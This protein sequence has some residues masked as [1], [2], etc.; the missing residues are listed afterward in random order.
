MAFTGSTLRSR[1]LW[2]YLSLFA[3]VFALIVW[4][5]VTLVAD[6]V[7]ERLLV[8]CRDL[9]SLVS[10][11]GFPLNMPTV[12]RLKEVLGADIIIVD[13]QGVTIATTLP[14][15]ADDITSHFELEIGAEDSAVPHRARLKSAR[16]LPPSIDPERTWVLAARLRGSMEGWAFYLFSTGDLQARQEAAVR[17]FLLLAG[18]ALL[19]VCLIGDRIA[20]S[21]S[22]PI[23]DLVAG[24]RAIAT[25]QREAR[26]PAGG[27]RELAELAA[28]FNRMVEDL[29][30]YEADLVRAGKM[31]AIGQMTGAVAHEIRNPLAAMKLTVQMLARTA[32]PADRE[33]LQLLEREIARLQFTVDELFDLAQP[34]A[35]DRAPGALEPVV[36]DILRLLEPEFAH[37]RV[38]CVREFT[39]VPEV[40]LDPRR[41]PRVA[42][43]LC[44]NAVQAMP[45]GGRLVVSIGRSPEGRVL[46]AVRDSGPGLPAEVRDRLFEPFVSTKEGGIG[47][48]LVIT[49]RLVEEHGGTLSVD[50]GPG[51]T[52]FTV[53]LPAA[54]RA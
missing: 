40:L 15:S 52:T 10:R 5:A 35:L 12:G 45:E 25:G 36:S 3:L 2:P 21:I 14:V 43:N 42:M 38:V 47:L 48:G 44:R 31:A 46:L 9:H 49:K 53:A 27:T 11:T 20:R 18:I 54:E 26:L 22:R 24:T 51:G 28:A 37:K 7:E 6:A 4:V 8:Q 41:F 1:I 33:S 17:P 23:D 34:P 30:R 13:R 39:P 16:D 19:A 29:R 32:P 50:S